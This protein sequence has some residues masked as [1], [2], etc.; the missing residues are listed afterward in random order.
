MSD[1]VAFL[2]TMGGNPSIGRLSAA[3]YAAAVAQLG[4]DDAQTNALLARDAQALND[5][6]GARKQ[7]ML[8]L[9]TPEEPVDEPGDDD[10]DGDDS[11]PKPDRNA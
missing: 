4:L 1:V 10:K 6:A 3:D 2:E 7:C 5:L 11:R 9:A 8:V